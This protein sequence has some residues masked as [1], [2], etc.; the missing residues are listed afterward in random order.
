[1]VI[2]DACQDSWEDFTTCLSECISAIKQDSKLNF[3]DSDNVFGVNAMIQDKDLLRK[4]V[5]VHQAALLDT[6]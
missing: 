1:L 6:L 3:G 4:F 5:S 2:T